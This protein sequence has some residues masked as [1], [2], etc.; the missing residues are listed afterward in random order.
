M[1][2]PDITSN[3]S[4]QDRDRNMDNLDYSSNK[5]NDK[6][7][8]TSGQDA[9][10]AIPAIEERFSL[11]KKTVVEDLKIEKRWISTIKKIEVPVNY[12][13][14]F[15][16]DKEIK[17]YK[18]DYNILSKVKD[19]IKD[20]LEGDA[21]DQEEDKD[22]K[23][24]FQYLVSEKEEAEEEQQQSNYPS[25]GILVPL[26][27]DNDKDK[28]RKETEKVIPIFTEEIVISK[29]IVKIGEAIIK[30]WK[31]TEEEKIDIDIRKEKISIE[32]PEGTKEQITSSS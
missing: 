27:D 31:V 17:S 7:Q 14:I 5:L 15:I 10:N 21:D 3:N 19:K 18:K 30:K 20:S 28:N 12:E 29:R 2:K 22:K 6:E 8:K 4:N 16:N 23:H 1:S 13:E 24:T 9:T 32:Y 26:F 25:D 11:E